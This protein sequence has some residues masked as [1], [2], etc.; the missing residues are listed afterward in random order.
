M[1]LELQRV[2]LDVEALVKEEDNIWSQLHEMKTTQSGMCFQPLPIVHPKKATY[3]GGKN[4]VVIMVIITNATTAMILP[5]HP[6]NTPSICFALRQCY[7][8]LISVLFVSKNYIWIGGLVGGFMKK[9]R[10]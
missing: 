1:E 5:S 6:A 2:I 8:N 7:Q 3:D 9:M 4:V 10:R